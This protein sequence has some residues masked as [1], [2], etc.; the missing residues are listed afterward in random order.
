MAKKDK[1]S[2]LSDQQTRHVKTDSDYAKLNRERFDKIK[3]EPLVG[4][5]GNP[6]YVQYLGEVY[7]FDYQDFPVTI[8]FD[9]KTYM[10]HKTIAEVLQKKLDSIARTNVPKEAGEGDRL[11]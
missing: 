5:Y 8:K 7:S 3:K 6:L 10:Y 2:Y 4:V 9:G 1:G 11:L